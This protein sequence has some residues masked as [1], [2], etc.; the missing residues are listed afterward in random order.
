LASSREHSGSGN[1]SLLA[2]AQQ[3]DSGV[4][5]IYLYH[6]DGRP[7]LIH[8]RRETPPV[9]KFRWF[10]LDSWGAVQWGRGP[11]RIGVDRVEPCYAYD[12]AKAALTADPSRELWSTEGEKDAETLWSRGYIAVSPADGARE[13]GERIEWLP[14]YIEAVRSLHPRKVNVVADNDAPGLYTA[15]AV[16]QALEQAS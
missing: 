13:P 8:A 16:A 12:R 10:H 7:V 14:A 5:R 9:P 2:E 1:S 6:R 4:I 15:E 11:H 3:L